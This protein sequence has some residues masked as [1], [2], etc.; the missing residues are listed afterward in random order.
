MDSNVSYVKCLAVWSWESA[1]TIWAQIPQ[2]NLGEIIASHRRD[3]K[4]E[5]VMK[6]VLRS[7][8]NT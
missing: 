7:V 2:Y 6:L 1:D 3:G 8:A 4:V 5:E